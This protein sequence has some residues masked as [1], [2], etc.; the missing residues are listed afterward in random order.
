VSFSA[1]C[2]LLLL[3]LLMLLLLLLLSPMQLISLAHIIFQRDFIM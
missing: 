1:G 2:W 3:L